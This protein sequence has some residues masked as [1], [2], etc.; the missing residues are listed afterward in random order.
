MTLSLRA[1]QPREAAPAGEYRDRGPSAGPGGTAPAAPGATEDTGPRREKRDRRRGRD[2]EGGGDFRQYMGRGDS[3]G[4]GGVT[5]GD[6]F[7]ELLSAS[8]PVAGKGGGKRRRTV[9]EEDEDLSD[10]D[11]DAEP[12]VDAEAAVVDAEAPATTETPVTVEAA[13]EANESAG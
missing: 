9:E 3:G 1:L 4:G 5:L 6:M 13:L 2:E 7:P 11:F 8:R 12:T 10:I